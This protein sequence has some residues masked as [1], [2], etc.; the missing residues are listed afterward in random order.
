MELGCTTSQ[1][2][3]DFLFIFLSASTCSALWKPPYRVL[4]GL[5]WRMHWIGTIVMSATYKCVQTKGCDLNPKRPVCSGSSWPLCATFLPPEYG[6]DPLWN[7]GFM[8]HNQIRALQ[9]A[10]ERKAERGILFTITRTMGVMSQ[11]P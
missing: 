11:K 1:H 9:W 7:R 6:Q 5:L 10:G 4:L 2:E 8:T 3:D